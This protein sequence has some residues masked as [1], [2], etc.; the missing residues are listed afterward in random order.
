M[1]TVE[2]NQSTL[3]KIQLNQDKLSVLESVV[4]NFTSPSRTSIQLTKSLTVISS[5][6]YS[7]TVTHLDAQLFID[8]TY[9]YSVTQDDIVLK[10]GFV[11]Y[12][13]GDGTEGLLFDYTLD[14]TLS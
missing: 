5:G 14:F 9:S 7:F 1:I 11:R 12:I 3:V 2:R 13:I 6:F 4:I 10:R 8:D